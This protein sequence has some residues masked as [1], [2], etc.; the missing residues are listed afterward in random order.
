[1]ASQRI[2][3]ITIEIGGDTT[4]LTKALSNVD[5]AVKETQAN[6][7]DVNKALKFDTGNV[8]LLKNK[9]QLLNDSVDLAKQKL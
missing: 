7:R 6:L 8:E 4:E 1:M 9:Q 2:K 3:G 5:K